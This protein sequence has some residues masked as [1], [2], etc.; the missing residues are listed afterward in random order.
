MRKV[1]A[2]CGS[3][4][5]IGDADPSGDFRTGVVLE[6]AFELKNIT[7]QIPTARGI[8]ISSQIMIQAIDLNLGNTKIT[9]YPDAAQRF[10]DMEDHD[11]KRYEDA[12]HTAKE[13]AT[14]QRA[15]SLGLALPP[16]VSKFTK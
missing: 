16:N 1:V 12:L 9:V 8:Q 10:T 2:Y 13:S 15:A 6:N 7:V 4:T 3:R 5:F 11:R 14:Q